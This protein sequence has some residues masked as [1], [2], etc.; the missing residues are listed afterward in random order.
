MNSGV[1]SLNFFNFGSTRTLGIAGSPG[2]NGG[3]QLVQYWPT[4]ELENT[5]VSN[6]TIAYRINNMLLI[7]GTDASGKNVLTMYDPE[8]N[9]EQIILDGSNEVEI[10]SF[11]YVPSTNKLMF[12]GLQFS[13]NKYVVAEVALP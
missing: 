2:G 9:Q 10:Y 7:T 5:I 11:A 8:T 3:T 12:N 4:L 1:Y 6:I 13:D